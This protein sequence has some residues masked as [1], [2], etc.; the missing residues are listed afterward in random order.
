MCD[1]A[2]IDCN[3]SKNTVVEDGGAA[4]SINAT[5]CIFSENSAKH[6][7]AMCGGEAKNCSFV[8]NFAQDGTNDILDVET[9]EGDCS[10]IVPKFDA[11]DFNTTYSYGGKFNFNLSTDDQMFNGVETIISISKNGSFVANYT[12]LTGNGWIVNLP[13]GTYKA[14]LSVAGS[15]IN[16]ISKTIIVAK[17]PTKITAS[18]VTAIYN[19]NK[20]LTIKLTDAKGKA[21]SGF[22]VTVTLGTAKTYTTDKNG[23][24]KIN[25]AKILPKT[26]TAKINFAG[27]ANIAASTKNVKV[28]VKKATPKMSAKAKTFRVKVKVKKYSI[29]LKNH[30][31][32]VFKNTKV[33]LKVNKKTF[34]AKTNKKGVATFKITNLK[35]KGKFTAIIRYAG[36]KY[37]NKLNRKVKI[38][39]K[40]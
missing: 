17:I 27:N 31:K 37:Y 11:S 26:Y 36:N 32:K 25:V 9:S 39:V 30:L 18:G 23:Q 35:R 38:T 7:G 21:L 24:I 15:N 34:T 33:T 1:G 16:P 6:G 10:F 40:K 8:L 22:K 5:G 2:A 28:V 20:Y 29:V 3:F 4:K 19:V 12:A 13:P 14:V